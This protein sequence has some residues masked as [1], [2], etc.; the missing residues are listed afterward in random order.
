M[1]FDTCG[2]GVYFNFGNASKGISDADISTSE[3]SRWT[4]GIHNGRKL[5]ILSS[6]LP[7]ILYLHSMWPE[8]CA[9]IKVKY[10]KHIT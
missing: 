9:Q 10:F 7:N 6:Y 3:H 8:G 5:Q 4:T 1:L 2:N